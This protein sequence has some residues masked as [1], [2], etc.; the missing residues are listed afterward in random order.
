[1]H[2]FMAL[3]CVSSLCSLDP[4]VYEVLQIVQVGSSVRSTI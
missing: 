2:K 3:V 1:M 4:P